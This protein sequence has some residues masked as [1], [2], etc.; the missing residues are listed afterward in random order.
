MRASQF[1]LSPPLNLI[2]SHLAFIFLQDIDED[3]DQYVNIR[4]SETQRLGTSSGDAFSVLIDVG[5]QLIQAVVVRRMTVRELQRHV[6]DLLASKAQLQGLA[7]LERVCWLSVV[8]CGRV[9]SDREATL[10][11]A[12][13]KGWSSLQL[14]GGLC[15]GGSD[16][17]DEVLI[18]DMEQ[19]RRLL[20]SIDPD[21]QGIL[22]DLGREARVAKEELESVLAHDFD[23][24]KFG[25]ATEKA[26]KAWA[27]LE[28]HLALSEP[29]DLRLA[30][31]VGKMRNMLE[32]MAPPDSERKVSPY[33]ERNVSPY[34]TLVTVAVLEGSNKAQKEAGTKLD[35][36]NQKYAVEIA[37]LNKDLADAV[38]QTKNVKKEHAKE[39]EIFQG[40]LADAEKQMNAM[41]EKESALKTAEKDNEAALIRMGTVMETLYQQVT[42]VKMK[43]GALTQ[44]MGRKE[45]ALIRV[46]QAMA[47]K[48][49]ALIGVENVMQELCREVNNAKME[50]R[51]MQERESHAR[52]EKEAALIRVEMMAEELKL[53]LL[54]TRKE[55]EK[56]KSDLEL[57]D[58]IVNHLKERVNLKDWE[59]DL[60][61]HP[62]ASSIHIMS[63]DLQ[64]YKAVTKLAEILPH[65]SES[66]IEL[67]LRYV[68]CFIAMQGSL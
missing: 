59:K 3:L 25:D 16:E 50:A 38:E 8:E 17:V 13:V 65:S 49:D 40:K 10:E 41:R 14:R 36:V 58:G 67:N 6:L 60:E 27:E 20:R 34:A 1:S 56:A 21:V 4:F 29:S 18:A 28:A 12:G 39:K 35:I 44:E 33:A 31:E 9:L 32:R 51:V 52:N 42:D 47:K 30:S 46:T 37:N 5:G 22:S 26:L 61:L 54:N 62:K 68:P 66:L 57:K 43:A 23:I 48:A 7:E 63:K 2:L 24:N 45:A 19:M 53:E 15:G 11:E 64:C 55:L